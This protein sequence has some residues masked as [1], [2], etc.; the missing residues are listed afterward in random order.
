MFNYPSTDV[1]DKVQIDGQWY[2]TS[3]NGEPVGLNF[4][5]STFINNGLIS[6]S[7]TA[8]SSEVRLTP[9]SKLKN[10]GT[11]FF[12]IRPNAKTH[13]DVYMKGDIVNDG[14]IVLLSQNSQNR[15][16]FKIDKSPFLNLGVVCAQRTNVFVPLPEEMGCVALKESDVHFTVPDLNRLYAQ[17]VH[18]K[19]SV[20]S[21]YVY[22]SEGGLQTGILVSGFGNGNRIILDWAPNK[23]RYNEEVGYFEF[24]LNTTTLLL[25]VGGGYDYNALQIKGSVITYSKPPPST[26]VPDQ[27]VCD[28]SAPV[29]P[30]HADQ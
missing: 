5:G 9:T 27:C 4:T 18:F 23:S 19:D 24:K 8:G 15:G 21:M 28:F 6:L 12:G 1:T 25:F 11:I 16:A 26:A 2:L 22:N 17:Q 29:A 14:K 3:S 20:S 30:N 7:N 13:A 10:Q